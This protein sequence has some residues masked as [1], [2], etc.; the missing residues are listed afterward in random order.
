[1]SSLDPA[2]QQGTNQTHLSVHHEHSMTSEEWRKP[3]IFYSVSLGACR[4]YM[5]RST[6]F[7]IT[8][9]EKTFSSYFYMY[10]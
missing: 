5:R 6:Y 2:H 1:M 9:T 7:L 10:M 4:E 8:D 3:Q